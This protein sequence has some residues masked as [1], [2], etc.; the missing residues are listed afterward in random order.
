MSYKAVI[1]DLDG[2]LVNSLYDLLDATNYALRLFGQQV[3]SSSALM[4]MIGD[5]TR[6][7]ISRALAADKQE[8]V[9]K[10][11]AA[12]REKYIE[13]CLDKT[14]PY[15]GLERVLE[16]LKTLRVRMAVLTN[17][18]QKMAEKIVR[19]LFGDT[20]EIIIGGNNGIPVK[21]EPTSLLQ[22]LKGLDVKP[23]EAL[24]VGDSN[25]D[26]KTAK[27]AKVKSVGVKWGFRGEAELKEAGA[28]FIIDTPLDLIDLISKNAQA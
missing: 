15:N 26:V 5:G 23:E 14:R 18:D 4:K 2:T 27:A 10:V 9:D 11:M 12:M 25:V 20:F 13:I 8:L 21:P 7:L 16:S 6:T 1:F 28:D 19:H 24:F 22:V 17:K 3:H